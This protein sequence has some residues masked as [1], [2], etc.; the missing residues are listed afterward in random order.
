[1][2]GL[3]NIAELSKEWLYNQDIFYS[4][5][6]W[7]AQPTYDAFGILLVLAFVVLG[8]IIVWALK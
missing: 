1:M 6:Y 3:L 8:L 7:L 2:E 5:D 4:L